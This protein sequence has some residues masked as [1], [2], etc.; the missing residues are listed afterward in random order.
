MVP[1]YGGILAKL[2]Y[3]G[4]IGLTILGLYVHKGIKEKKI[5]KVRDKINNTYVGCLQDAKAVEEYQECEKLIF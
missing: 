2:A 3:T 1:W 4:V 5:R